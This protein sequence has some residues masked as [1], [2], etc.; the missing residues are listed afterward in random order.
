MFPSRSI[1]ATLPLPL[2]LLRFIFPRW[3]PFQ[4]VSFLHQL[5]IAL[6]IAIARLGPVVFPDSGTAGAMSVKE[7]LAWKGIVQTLVQLTANA[8]N[9]GTQAIFSCYLSLSDVETQSSFSDSDITNRANRNT[10]CGRPT[11]ATR[12]WGGAVS[13]YRDHS[14]VGD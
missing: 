14:D 9:E 6:S 11:T 5:Y 1:L 4:H 2:T 10:R 13:G 3:V 12:R 7:E 8:D